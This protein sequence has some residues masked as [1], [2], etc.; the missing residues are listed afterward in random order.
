MY[1]RW[2]SEFYHKSISW[3]ILGNVTWRQGRWHYFEKNQSINLHNLCKLMIILLSL[4]NP[5][6]SIVIED[7]FMYL[8]VKILVYNLQPWPHHMYTGN[9]KQFA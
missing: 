1:R 2:S 7:W 8:N 4:V 5:M 9:L 3:N 6:L